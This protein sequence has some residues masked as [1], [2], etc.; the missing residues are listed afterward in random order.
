MITNPIAYPGALVSGVT[1]TAQGGFS[2]DPAQFM[3]ILL[4][5]LR[6]QNPLDPVQDKDFMGQMTQMNSLQELQKMNALLK[7][8]AQSNHLT[9]AAA[10]IGKAVTARG[11]DG[12]TQ[13]GVVTGVTLDGDEA[14]LLVGGSAIALSSVVG[15]SA[16]DHDAVQSM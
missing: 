3:Q 9:E 11:D 14:R 13:T 16:V 5:Q 2:D 1:Q 10:L 8:L 15:V 7:S 12:Q 4:A 6:N